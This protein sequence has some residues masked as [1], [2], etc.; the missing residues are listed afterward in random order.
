MCGI[1]VAQ[2]MICKPTKISFSHFRQNSQGLLLSCSQWLSQTNKTT[3]LTNKSTFINWW[4]FLHL[5]RAIFQVSRTVIQEVIDILTHP[6][7]SKWNIWNQLKVAH[8]KFLVIFY[9]ISHYC[10][11]HIFRVNL[12]NNCLK[13]RYLQLSLYNAKMKFYMLRL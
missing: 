7:K 13:S 11:F 6:L 5:S 4:M 10:F 1:F 8:W 3:Q 2:R 9:L 12:S